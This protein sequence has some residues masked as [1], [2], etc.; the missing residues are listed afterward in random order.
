MF[1]FSALYQHALIQNP[2]ILNRYSI[3]KGIIK[4]NKSSKT[5]R[6]TASILDNPAELFI[7]V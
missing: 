4:K 3:D 5:A 7:A 6:M 2:R 1:L